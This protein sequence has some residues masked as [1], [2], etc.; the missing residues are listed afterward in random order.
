[1]TLI[2]H[3]S[4]RI[5]LSLESS[6]ANRTIISAEIG[7]PGVDIQEDFISKYG[8]LDEVGESCF[9]LTPLLFLYITH[10]MIFSLGFVL[11]KYFKFAWFSSND[12]PKINGYDKLDEDRL[13]LHSL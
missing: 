9:H 10:M 13:S 12:N 11:Y 4:S 5:D 3:F 8:L 1:M 6:L 7:E 2:W